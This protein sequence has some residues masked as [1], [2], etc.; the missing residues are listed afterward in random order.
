MKKFFSDAGD[1]LVNTNLYISACSFFYT[2]FCCKLLEIEN[3]KALSYSFLVALSVFVIYCVQRLYFIVVSPPVTRREH[4]YH[5]NRWWLWILVIIASIK[6]TDSIFSLSPKL[7]L[8]FA[9]FAALSLL[10]YLGP[11]PL[12]KVFMLKGFVIGIVWAAVCVAVPF[13]FFESAVTFTKAACLAGAAF[14]FVAAL[15]IPF[16]IRDIEDDFKKGIRSMPLVIGEKRSKI[17]GT[18]LMLCRLILI[19]AGNFQADAV[20]SVSITTAITIGGILF[21]SP[22]RNRFYFSVFIDGMLLLPYLFY[23]FF[24]HLL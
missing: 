10:Y 21:S 3:S 9:P 5:T 12:R 6:L 20:M 8:Y 13:Y 14:L 4:W 24:R 15:C 2:L 16:D 17:T 18:L 19:I 1:F 11:I 7:I 22:S 23:L